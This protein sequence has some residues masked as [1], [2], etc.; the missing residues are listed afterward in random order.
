MNSDKNISHSVQSKFQLTHIETNSPHPTVSRMAMCRSD[1][2]LFISLEWS[3]EGGDKS[4]QWREETS[5]VK[6]GRRQV[7]SLEGGD[8]SGHWREETSR[9]NG[10]RR[11]V[12]SKEG[13]DKSGQW[14]EE[15][16]RVIGGR[17]Q[18]GSLAGG[19]K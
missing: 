3:M 11:Q 13:G 10:G 9:V 19:D 1:N 4:G 17:R 14:R 2:K 5:R 8:K 18:V 12:G 6:G 15:T 16:S 7:G